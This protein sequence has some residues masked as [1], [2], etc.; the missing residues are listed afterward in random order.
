MA[1]CSCPAWRG[2]G[3]LD[4]SIRPPEDKRTCRCLVSF[5]G[6]RAEL[7]RVDGAQNLRI[8]MAAC[9]HVGEARRKR[10]GREG[11]GGGQRSKAGKVEV[12]IRDS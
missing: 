5:L 1:S 2:Q 10:K 9:G 8:G 3:L 7:K 6:G 11:E 12:E 4:E